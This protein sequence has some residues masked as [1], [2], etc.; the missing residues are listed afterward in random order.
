VI[1]YHSGE[2]RIVKHAFRD[3]KPV[4][5]LPATATRV[6][7]PR[8]PAGPPAHAQADP[9]RPAEVRANRGL[10]RAQ[11]RAFEVTGEDGAGD[12]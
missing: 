1:T 9:S 6:H 11:L 3:W 7:L 2:D 10:A 12:G 4:V 8:A 5:R